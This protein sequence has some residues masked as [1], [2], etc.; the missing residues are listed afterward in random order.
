[1]N[2]FL[3]YMRTLLAEN[4]YV[5]FNCTLD[6]KYFTFEVQYIFIIMI[7]KIIIIY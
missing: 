7:I 3:F 5:S 4:N 6:V 1:M 2:L